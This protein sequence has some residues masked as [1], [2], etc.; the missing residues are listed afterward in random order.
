MKREIYL[1]RSLGQIRAAVVEDGL[2][3][4]LHT[5]RNTEKKLTET[6]FLGRVEQ[7]RPS[8]GA[9][10]VN[11][12][13]PLNAFLPLTPEDH[14]RCGD[15]ILVQGAAK[16]AT[17][18]KGL[19]VSARLN[20]AGKWLVLIPGE[21][22]I[23]ISKKVKH[24]VLREELTRLAQ[25]IC[26]PNCAL[27]VRTASE[28]VTAEAMQEEVQRLYARW[29]EIDRLAR[30]GMRPGI[31][32]DSAPLDL[33][34]VRDMG[35]KALASVV[36]NDES[37][38][39]RLLAEQKDGRIPEQTNLS[40]YQEKETLL[41]DI[42][43]VEPQIDKA[44]KKRVWLPCGGYLIIDPCEAMTVIDVNSGKMVLGKDTEETAI[45][46]NMEAAEE[47]ARQIRLRDIGG[48]IVV[49]FI[50]M[51]E[52]ENRAALIEHMKLAVKDDRSV[53]K[54]EGIT[55]LGLLEMT[56]KR[57]NAS[58]EKTLRCT[59]TYCSGMGTLLA[60]EETAKRALR[61][62]RRLALSGQRGPFV[63]RCASA[64]ANALLAEKS[65]IEAPIYA[66]GM[67]SRH[68][69]RF[70]IEQIGEADPIPSG[71]EAIKKD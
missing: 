52:K 60:P 26:P 63:I 7:I 31:V 32:S 47:I 17:E 23:H 20:L 12:G 62:I 40:F 3:R 43:G 22:G 58:L 59:C 25:E 65:E 15:M 18:T 46:V 42:F 70:D 35:G 13:Q 10:F 30:S 1:D 11:I 21:S 14:Y 61:Q 44:L 5:E 67:P 29:L 57:V 48:I 45:R 66:L 6:V 71:A 36:T 9:A 55:R 49:D 41:F 34:L 2:L 19:R 51:A 38:Y 37:C 8:V 53:V 54:V 16:Q 68:A 64:V 39:R 4:E 50:D 33:R 24:A 27:I 69:E 28:D 56:R